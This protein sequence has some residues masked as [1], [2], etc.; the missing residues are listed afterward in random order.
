MAIHALVVALQTSSPIMGKELWP[1]FFFGFLTVLFITSVSWSCHYLHR[2]C[3][4][5]YLQLYGLPFWKKLP[6]WS[7]A[8]PVI[9]YIIVLIVAYYFLR[10]TEGRRF[11]RLA[12]VIRIPAIYYMLFIVG[13]LIITILLK[14]EKVFK[15]KSSSEQEDNNQAH[16]EESKDSLGKMSVSEVKVE[17]RSRT[18]VHSNQPSLVKQIGILLAVLVTYVICVFFSWYLEF[19]DVKVNL[20]VLTFVYSFIYMPVS[21][22][23]G[24]VLLK[25]I[26]PMKNY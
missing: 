25:Q 5:L 14:L 3:D 1:M 9:L 8:I 15:A 2:L 23:I 6:A 7:R 16:S 22:I 24:S 21:G 11:V 13:W 4:N 20:I 19:I 17:S 26:L 10:D 12:E 18:L